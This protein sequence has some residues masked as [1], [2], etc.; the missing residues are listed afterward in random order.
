MLGNVGAA[1]QVFERWMEWEPD[2]NGCV[3]AGLRL[4]FHICIF[5]LTGCVVATLCVPVA[6][7]TYAYY[8]PSVHSSPTP[9]KEKK[10]AA[11]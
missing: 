9:Q 5:A 1:R 4:V 3:R 6:L 2:D 7:C 11:F 10:L 8:H